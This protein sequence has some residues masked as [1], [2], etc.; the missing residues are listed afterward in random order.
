M[1]RTCGALNRNMTAAVP[2]P[3]GLGYVLARLRRWDFAAVD[4][5]MWVEARDL[6]PE[7]PAILLGG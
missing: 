2:S 6:A 7:A 4:L 5:S 1:C 3:S